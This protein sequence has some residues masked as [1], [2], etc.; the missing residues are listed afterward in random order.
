[1]VKVIMNKTLAT[2]IV[3]V[4]VGFGVY[5]AL[6]NMSQSATFDPKNATYIVEGTTV[7]LVNGESEIEAAPG[8]DSKVT[9]KYFGNGAVGDL[10]GD[11]VPDTA[12]LI[13]QNGGGTGTFYYVVAVLNA[14]GGFTAT[15]A[16]FLG[17]RIAPQTTEIQDG[18]LIVNF[19]DRGPGKP[20]TAEP[21]LAVSKYL[22]VEDGM[23]KEVSGQ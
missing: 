12:F 19:A 13:T 7:T 16:F 17:D 11:G 18:Q 10:N 8:S 3:I 15:D 9:T 21:S 23:L 1:M 6:K 5:W 14:N 22:V 2:A 20:F 4:L